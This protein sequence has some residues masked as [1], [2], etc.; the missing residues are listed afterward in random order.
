MSNVNWGAIEAVSTAF[1]A[2]ASAVA[3][4]LAW[5]ATKRSE[6]AAQRA[7]DAAERAAEAAR[8]MEQI[9]RQRWHADL[10]PDFLVRWVE[11]YPGDVALLRVDLVDPPGLGRLDRITLRVRDDRLG[12]GDEDQIAGGASREQLK[13]HVWGPY[14]FMWGSDG[15]DKHGR[16]VKPFALP[17]GEGRPYAMVRTGPP[18]GTEDNPFAGEQWRKVQDGPVRLEFLCERD[19]FEPWTVTR[20]VPVPQAPE[21]F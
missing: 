1:A 2:G 6:G 16:S 20:E 7:N 18:P 4:V 3:T 14:K 19:G 15:V 21:V 9:E 10:T 12:H 17:L 8:S 13:A 11:D 5:R